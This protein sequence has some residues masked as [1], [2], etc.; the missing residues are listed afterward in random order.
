[1]DLREFLD[2]LISETE[3]KMQDYKYD[4]KSGKKE[5]PKT[6]QGGDNEESEGSMGGKGKS[7]STA[8]G[9][10]ASNVGGTSSFKRAVKGNK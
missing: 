7:K 3:N 1:M 9:S 4:T 10:T 2:K 6:K 5:Q 8:A